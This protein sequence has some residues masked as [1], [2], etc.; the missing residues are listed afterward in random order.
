MEMH[1]GGVFSR[2]PG[3]SDPYTLQK[4]VYRKVCTDVLLLLVR[5]RFLTL[6]IR[7]WFIENNCRL[8]KVGEIYGEA[9]CRRM[10]GLSDELLN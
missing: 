8:F 7:D 3:F 1:S 5:L 4:A 10:I 6:H 9:V 2:Q